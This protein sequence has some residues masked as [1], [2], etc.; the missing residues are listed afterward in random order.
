MQAINI[1]NSY[2]NFLHNVAILT[3]SSSLKLSEKVNKIELAPSDLEV[4]NGDSV[5]VTG[6]G[7]QVDGG[8]PYKLQQLTMEVLASSECEL[9]AGYGYESVICLKHPIG[10]GICRGDEGAGIVNANKQLVGV[11]SFAFGSCGTK[12]PDISSKVA[13]YHDWIQSINA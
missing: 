8:S 7:L 12:Y 9:Q 4:N 13:Y 2:G 3:L 1:H 11:A 5:A 10:S 6:W